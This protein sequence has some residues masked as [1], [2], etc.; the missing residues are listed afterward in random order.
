MDI[1]LMLTNSNLNGHMQLV[2]TILDNA[3]KNS[4]GGGGE[5]K[6]P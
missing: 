5:Q 4:H 2:A 6:L 1:Q 3:I